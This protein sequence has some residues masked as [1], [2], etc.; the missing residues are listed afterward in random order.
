MF[1]SVDAIQNTDFAPS[2]FSIERWISLRSKSRGGRKWESQCRSRFG[3]RLSRVRSGKL[4]FKKYSFF[5]F[6]LEIWIFTSQINLEFTNREHPLIRSEF[7]FTGEEIDVSTRNAIE[8]LTPPRSI[9]EFVS[10]PN[11]QVSR[12]FATREGK[13]ICDHLMNAEGP[14]K[15]KLPAASASWSRDR[16]SADCAGNPAIWSN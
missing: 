2:S 3:W 14:S 13:Q 5:L 4:L 9:F 11:F 10:P 1:T 16:R 12:N 15:I 6:E 7:F 8:H